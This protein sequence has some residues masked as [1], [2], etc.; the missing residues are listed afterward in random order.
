MGA[1]T[2]QVPDE[3]PIGAAPAPR[4]QT[5]RRLVEATALP[6]FRGD[7]APISPTAG[8]GLNGGGGLLPGQLFVVASSTKDKMPFKRSAKE[9][10]DM[11]EVRTRTKCLTLE[12]RAYE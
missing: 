12:A 5:H 3:T 6:A 8:R 7:P 4:L 9:L 10:A 2:A 1:I 11:L